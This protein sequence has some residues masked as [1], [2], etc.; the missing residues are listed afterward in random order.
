[1]SNL[2]IPEYPRGFVYGEKVR[3]LP[4]GYKTVESVP[5]LYIHQW[6]DYAYRE[7]STS[8][9]AI[10]GRCVSTR[11]PNESPAD[12]LIN[13]LE[14][15]LEAF[16]EVMLELSGRYA[17]IF[18]RGDGL[19]FVTDA[20]GMRSVFYAYDGSIVA[21]HARL[22]E[23]NLGGPITRRPWVIGRG[24]PGNLV[25]Y[26]RTR[27]L[28]P[29]TYYA[30]SQNAVRRFWPTTEI[31]K[32]SVEEASTEVLCRMTNG[33]KALAEENKIRSTLTA[34]VDSRCL[35]AAAL[36]SG[37]DFET[38]TYGTRYNTLVDRQAAA[39][40]SESFGI[41]HTVP[42]GGKLPIELKRALGRANYT[43]HHWNNVE[44]L[45]QWIDDPKS[46]VLMEVLLEIGTGASAVSLPDASA[47]VDGESM[48]RLYI[49]TM[50]YKKR[51]ALEGEK[52]T[53]YLDFA[54]EAFG[55]WIAETGGPTPSLIDPFV[56]FFWEHRMA[57]WHGPTMAERD[58][59]ADPIHVS[60]S[61]SIY[62]SMLGV[63][64]LE[65]REDAVIREIWRQVEPRLL[66]Y[67]VNPK[68]W[69][70]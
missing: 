51:R 29:N 35:F 36:A 62:R 45:M 55:E 70:S 21:S 39:T 20:A 64:P 8:F 69:I 15:S 3:F 57:T 1:M 50:P 18:S 19:N 48:A 7:K 59:Y 43:N 56:Q 28:T 49:R 25:P 26:E 16:F 17:V 32:L 23:E 41:P 58:F 61:V 68:R 42:N 5:N 9:I 34:G 33:I 31:P 52:F 67:P 40:I 11:E 14:N 10:I 65:Q 22:V 2:R 38:Y 13:A 44:G 4:E 53:E 54:A 60:N 46:V 37:V 47:P 27:I 6:A 63:S 24:Y 30:Q 12:T 66:S